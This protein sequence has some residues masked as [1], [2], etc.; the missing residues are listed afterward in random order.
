MPSFSLPDRV[1]ALSPRERRVLV[2]LAEALPVEENSVVMGVSPQQVAGVRQAL[3]RKLAVP[4]GVRLGDFIHQT[5]DL[6][7]LAQSETQ[8]AQAFLNQQHQHKDTERR[9]QLLLRRTIQE[10]ETLIE[11]AV[12]RADALG[13]MALP[14]DGSDADAGEGDEADYLRDIAEELARVRREVLARVRRTD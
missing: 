13:G 12:A 7:P 3:R 10:I 8:A 1:A 2:L 4:P 9:R 5:P 11:R 6:V 14:G